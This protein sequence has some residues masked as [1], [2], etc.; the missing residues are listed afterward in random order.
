[1]EKD[2]V[3]RIDEL[4]PFVMAAAGGV[5]GSKGKRKMVGSK[6]VKGS[7]I[8]DLFLDVLYHKEPDRK[9]AVELV[10]KEKNLDKKTAKHLRKY[11]KRML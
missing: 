1:M 10:I 9:K 4:L 11:V 7:W 5:L 8:D 6:R 3:D 2:I